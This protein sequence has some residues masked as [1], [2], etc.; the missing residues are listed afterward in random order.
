[1]QKERVPI[2][3]EVGKNP[4]QK[5]NSQMTE[6]S[7]QISIT[8]NVAEEELRYQK[9][10]RI[11]ELEEGLESL[12]REMVQK[13]LKTSLKVIDDQTA[14]KVPKGWRNVGSETRQIICSLGAVSYKRR[15]YLD[16]ENRRRKPVDEL[17]GIERYGR[18]SSR[19]QVMG[20]YL[21]STGTYRMAAEQLSWL[22][23]TLTQ[24]M[25]P[26]G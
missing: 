22:L 15:I 18:A 13:V 16:E 20:S 8:I 17:I 6:N 10:I 3:I 11:G 5:R 12:N 7:V 24:W 1:L 25:R 9:E 19:V 2:S 4:T 14:E 21:A 23:K 26:E